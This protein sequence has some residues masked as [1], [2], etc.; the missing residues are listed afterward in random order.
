MLYKDWLGF[1]KKRKEDKLK[2]K[3]KKVVP[4]KA[5]TCTYIVL[6]RSLSEFI[7]K[8]IHDCLPIPSLLHLHVCVCVCVYAAAITKQ[9]TPMTHQNTFVLQVLLQVFFRY[10]LLQQSQSKKKETVGRA[11]LERLD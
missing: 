4:M 10:K 1:F 11:W 9:N 3:K 5:K 2:E 6:M 7:C 8:K